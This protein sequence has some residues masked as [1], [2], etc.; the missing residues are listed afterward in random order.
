MER[1]MQF[2][3]INLDRSVDRLQWIMQRMD[4][5]RVEVQRVAAVDGKLLSL[6]EIERWEKVRHPRFGM[7]PGEFACFLSHRKAWKA[8]L[9]GEDDWAFV[10][11]DDIHVSDQFPDFL[12][13]DTWVPSDANLVKA[14]TAM[15]RVWMAPSV[16]MLVHG[17]SLHV[18]KSFHGGSA[19]YFVDK[20]T[21]SWLLDQTETFC[22]TVDQLLFNPD[23]KIARQ[24]TNY[25]VDPALAIQDWA[26]KT[27]PAGGAIE[28]LLL[29]E[30]ADFHE[31]RQA[32]Y[33]SGPRYLWYKLSNPLVKASR[34]GI[35]IAANTVGTHRVKKVAFDKRT[36]NAAA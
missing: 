36:P 18:L 14:E 27:G 7:G 16:E 12:A 8:V 19:A 20:K 5:L 17:H 21:A 34:K 33:G 31:K 10:A 4:S 22:T 24:L 13:N 26:Y 28:S 15:Q 9:R 35:E 23:F 25:Q 29:A 6:D 1:M 3:L 11:E 2:Y 30:R 32:R